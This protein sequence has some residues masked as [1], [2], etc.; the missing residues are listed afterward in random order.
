MTDDGLQRVEEEALQE[1]MKAQLDLDDEHPVTLHPSGIETGPAYI[2]VGALTQ[3][4]P[5]I[6]KI[7]AEGLNETKEL[8]GEVCN[9]L[10]QAFEVDS[11][12]AHELKQ[13]ILEVE[14][15]ISTIAPWWVQGLGPLSPTPLNPALNV[16]PP[17]ELPEQQVSSSLYT[18]LN[19]DPPPSPPS[20]GNG[21]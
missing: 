9:A 7:Y 20:S 16:I 12:T 4:T 10:T 21:R 8:M 17:L 13:E 6:E 1:V 2:Y 18:P 5:E 14:D 19:F 11:E 15:R 3:G